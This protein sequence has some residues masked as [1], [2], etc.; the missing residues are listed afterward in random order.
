MI[1]SFGF[2]ECIQEYVRTQVRSICLAARIRTRSMNMNIYYV[3][4]VTH[5]EYTLYSPAPLT[6]SQPS[7]VVCKS[8]VNSRKEERERP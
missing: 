8:F 4:S 5:K 7:D 3:Y 1:F 6:C 2:L